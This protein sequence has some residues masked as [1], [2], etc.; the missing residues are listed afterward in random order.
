MLGMVRLVLSVVWDPISV[1]GH[2]STLDE[3]DSY[4]SR[5]LK[6]AEFTK[7]PELVAALLRQFEEESIGMSRDENGE[8]R[9]L[10]ET[11]ILRA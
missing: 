11:K 10:A 3:Y 2:A 1:F 9:L 5:V 7:S 6:A 4:A 8:A